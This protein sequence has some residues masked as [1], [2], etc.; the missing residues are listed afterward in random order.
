MELNGYNIKMIEKRRLNKICWQTV[1]SG[2]VYEII[3]KMVAM[4]KS[5]TRRDAK[6]PV[7]NPRPRQNNYRKSELESAPKKSEPETMPK[8]FVPE[9]MPK[10]FE[11]E[12]WIQRYWKLETGFH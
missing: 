12:T 10:N 8:N 1:E 4:V 5:E 3:I 9:T 6:T 2:N 7:W 11:P